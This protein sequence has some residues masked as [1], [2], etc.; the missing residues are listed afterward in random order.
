[1]V[2]SLTQFAAV[3]A[4]KAD[5]FT[6]LGLDWKALVLQTIAFLVLLVILR[7]FVYPPLLAILDKR[8]ADLK[9]S[10]KA[11]RQAKAAADESEIRTAEMLKKAQRDS[12]AIVTSAK[13]EAEELIADAEAKAA[14]QAERIIE[15]GRASVAAELAAAKKEL[16]GEMLDLV[17]EAT[18]AVTRQTVDA[19]SNAKLV[20][21]S[22]EELK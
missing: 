21:K 9:L 4:E 3:H 2:K 1:M 5:M 22:L 11:A 10:A 8:D 15:K 18:S 7:K 12:K 19:S 20:E 17:V 6:S 13:K 14:S 16:R